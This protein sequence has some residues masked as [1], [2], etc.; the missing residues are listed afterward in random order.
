MSTKSSITSYSK[1]DGKVYYWF[2]IYLGTDPLTGKQRNTTRRG[3]KTKREAQLE[4][5]RLKVQVA[6]GT[7]KQSSNKTFDDMYDMWIYQYEKTVEESTFVKTEGLFKNHILPAMGAYRLESIT[8]EICQKH[9]DEWA[10]KLKNASVLKHYTQNVLEAA[11]RHGFIQTNPF[12]HVQTRRKKSYTADTQSTPEN[13]YTVEELHTFLE[14]AKSHLSHKEYACLHLLAYT[15]IRKSE[16]LALT[17]NDL[18]FETRELIVDKTFGRGKQAKLYV[19]PTKT[20][21]RRIL[22]LDDQTTSV[23]KTWRKQQQE[24]YLKL[25]Y[26]TLQPTQLIFSNTQND[27]IQP[28]Q[29]NKWMTAIQTKCQLKPVKPHGLR[30]T[31]CSLLFEAGMNIKEVQDRLGHAD[32]KTTLN[33]Y[34]HI[35]NK[36]KHEVA[37]KYE[38]YVKSR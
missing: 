30:H 13:H 35:S 25:G 21:D 1:K 38:A 11:I 5:N 15:G 3:F 20:N 4:Y 17:W 31:H 9:Y 33:V 34:T 18:N 27:V 32:A 36:A 12:Q 28:I 22:A 37:A 26:N 14:H 23:L 10:E 24:D 6:D 8:L 16:A 2:Q 7:Y 19:K 29:V